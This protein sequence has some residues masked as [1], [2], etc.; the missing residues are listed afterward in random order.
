MESV[1]G[2]LLIL[3]NAERIFRMVTLKIESAL[4]IF[5]PFFD[6]ERPKHSSQPIENCLFEKKNKMKTNI[7]SI[8]VQ[9]QEFNCYSNISATF[10]DQSKEKKYTII[11]FNLSCD[12]TIIHLYLNNII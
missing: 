10:C 7:E 9:T 3:L 12:Y 6:V 4:F 11:Y 1:Y 8:F 5:K 2:D